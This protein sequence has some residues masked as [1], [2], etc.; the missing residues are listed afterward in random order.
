MTNFIIIINKTCFAVCRS[1][2][3]C[4]LSSAESSAEEDWV[5]YLRLGISI[6]D[7]EDLSAFLKK[8][9]PNQPSEI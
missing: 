2:Q 3:V 1:V 4:D 8:S 6:I 7:F 9:L 5:K